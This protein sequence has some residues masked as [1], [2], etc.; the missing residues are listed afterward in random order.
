M[1][2]LATQG[3]NTNGLQ[4]LIARADQFGEKKVLISNG[5]IKKIKKLLKEENQF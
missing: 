3:L 1:K 5:T 4:M 2:N